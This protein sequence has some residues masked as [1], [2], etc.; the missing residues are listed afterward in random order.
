[1]KKYQGNGE[2]DKAAVEIA[3][4][5]KK[6]KIEFENGKRSY[7]EFR[8]IATYWLYGQIKNLMNP[9][10]NKTIAD[11]QYGVAER[12]LKNIKKDY[13][14]ILMDLMARREKYDEGLEKMI[15]WIAQLEKKIK[16]LQL[17]VDDLKHHRSPNH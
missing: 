2:T 12:A 14:T 5:A 13:P 1:M 16:T 11:F 9:P 15:K 6:A 4:M 8:Q 10:K 17:E 7:L 3:E